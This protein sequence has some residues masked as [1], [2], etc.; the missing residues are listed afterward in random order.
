[1]KKRSIYSVI[2]INLINY[3][4]NPFLNLIHEI[5]VL[6]NKIED[7]EGSSNLQIKGDKQMRIN[8]SLHGQF[9]I[10]RSLE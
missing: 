5:E 8:S 10:H 4:Q 3:M 2:L 7:R 9:W 1:M 6:K